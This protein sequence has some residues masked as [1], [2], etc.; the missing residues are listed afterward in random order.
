MPRSLPPLTWFRAFEA[1]ARRLSFTAAADELGLTQSAISQQVRALETRLGVPLFQRKPRGLALTDDGRKLLPKVG[2]AIEQLAAAADAFDAGPTR[3]L[4]TIATSVSVAQW[5]LAPRLSGFM[6]AHP[7]LRVRLLGAIWPDEFNASI[8]DVEIRFGSKKQVG[9]SATRLEPDMLIAVAAPGMRG[10][11]EELALIEAVG[12]A[13]GWRQWAAQARCT[14]PLEPTI[15][16]DSYGLALDLARNGAG[17]ALTSSLLAASALA[18]GEVERA[19]D[20]ALAS[21]EGYFI[22]ADPRS[23]PASAFA[24]WLGAVLAETERT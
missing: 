15:H 19:H 3:G 1:A 8:A 4:L 9:D 18:A 16:V 20:A 23:D 6:N 22:A 5:I 14:A 10:T 13:E 21:T 11:L 24:A 7:G 17:V 2:A 12:A